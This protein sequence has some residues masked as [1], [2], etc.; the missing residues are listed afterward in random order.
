MMQN[1][2]KMEK[3]ELSEKLVETADRLDQY[4]TK[5]LT[6][7]LWL[8]LRMLRGLALSLILYSFMSATFLYIYEVAGLE[9]VAVLLGVSIVFW[10]VKQQ[11]TSLRKTII[12]EQLL[13]EE[14]Q[15]RVDYQDGRK[16]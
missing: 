9:R 6:K 4:D 14:R 13:K 1:T 12:L 2:K 15:K 7:L 16:S 8:A 10:G 5:Q 3:K 11:L